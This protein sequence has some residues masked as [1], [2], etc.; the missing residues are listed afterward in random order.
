VLAALEEGVV[1]VDRDGALLQANAAASAILERLAES[2]ER[3]REALDVARLASWEWQ[4]DTGNV[5][6]FQALAE[7][8]LTAGTLIALEEW[9]AMIPASE[10]DGV[11]ADF[12]AY[13][14]GTCEESL[15]TIV[16]PLPGGPAWLEVRSRAVR[17]P[18]GRL[19]CVRGT[20]QDVS[21]REVAHRELADAHDFLQATLDSLSA[22][23]VVLDERGEI[24]TVNR[25]WR[26]YGAANA[27]APGSAE[28]GANYLAACDAAPELPDAV[29]TARGLRAIS[30]GDAKAFSLEYRCDRPNAR[31]WFQL[32]ATRYEGPGP[33]RVVVAH[34]DITQRKESELS[35]VSSARHLRAVTDSMGEGVYT[36]DADGHATY[37]NRSAEDLLGWSMEKV[38]GRQMH[39]LVHNRRPDGSERPLDECQILRAWREG[40][41][42]RVPDDTFIRPDGSELPVAYTAS[43]F[44]T[45]EGPAGC[46]VVFEDITR[47]KADELMVESD[48]D[49][50]EWVARVEEALTRDRFVLHAQPIVALRSGEVVQHELLIRMRHPDGSSLPGL[51]PPSYFLPVAEEFGQIAT[52]DR[53][54]ID[55]AAEYAAGKMPIELNV[56]GRSISDPRLV[57]YIEAAINR[58][59]AD[60]YSM[61][62]EITETTMVSNELAARSFVERLHRLGC[63]IAL[64]D[65]GTGYGGF[66]YVK[67]L[68]IDFL[69]IDIEFVSDLRFNPASAS[70]IQ[71]IVNLAQGFGLQTIAEGVEDGDTME[72]LRELGVDYAQG[73]HVGRP[74]PVLTTAEQERGA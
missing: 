3:L 63:K 58:T 28:V 54:V 41:T 60:P 8:D 70:V 20:A 25:A 48:L 18:E 35:L 52:I 16:H 11:N 69:K 34:E 45:N 15:R 19:L 65:F 71:A 6:V 12:A 67:Q 56:S 73:Y 14:Q 33:L 27:A 40:E 50:L 68:P 23:V 61:V 44:A 21:E 42:V 43:P 17:D 51:I 46:V 30:A 13:V 5:L 26:E 7:S 64:D 38:A 74:A 10:H 1:V 37:M 47:R 22:H 29:R 24:V 32:R 31:C 39:A 62:F 2:Q 49:K 36:V 72:L 4:P 57:D 53:W 55:R 59:G 66:T 9:L